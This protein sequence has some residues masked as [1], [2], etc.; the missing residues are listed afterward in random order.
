MEQII[1]SASRAKPICRQVENH[2]RERILN[3]SLPA[4]HKLPTNQDL[5]RQIGTSVFTIQTALGRLCREGLLVRKTGVGTFVAGDASRLACLGIYL[6]HPIDIPEMGFCQALCRRIKETLSPRG[7]QVRY[8]SDERDTEQR[9][10]PPPSLR[11]AVE[12][13]EIQGLIVPAS[14]HLDLQWLEELK[15][16][17]A[18]CTS[19]TEIPRRVIS[20]TNQLLQL[21]LETLREQG[22][23]TVG[24]ISSCASKRVDFYGA[25]LDLIGQCGLRTS[26]S[27]IAAVESD[28]VPSSRRDFGYHSTHRILKAKTRPDGLIVWPDEVAMGV[29][30]ALLE[31]RIDI[32]RELNVILH[33]N[34]ILA[35]P[36]PFPAT[37]MVTQVGVWADKLIEM[38]DDQLRG[39]EVSPVFLP[40]LLRKAPLS[41]CYVD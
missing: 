14:S 39:T 15:V 38:I 30:T 3:R 27:W 10:S 32:P 29:V 20:H 34:D 33:V 28:E 31:S 12:R 19:N 24:L 22:C 21:S 1:P 13:R 17:I 18:Y 35:Y 2:L 36:C 4:G 40:S 26:N 37:L 41:P 16:P 9:T 11:D 8:W 7:V 25:F 5:A 6:N 23:R